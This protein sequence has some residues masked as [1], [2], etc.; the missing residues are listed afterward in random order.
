MILQ[1]VEYEGTRKPAHARIQDPGATIL[2]LRIPD[3]PDTALARARKAGARVLASAERYLLL[4]DDDGFVVELSG[5]GPAGTDIEVAV[6]D[7]D[8][9][10]AA[11]RALGFEPVRAALQDN[12]RSTVEI[13]GAVGGQIRR[14]RAA[15]PDAAAGATASITFLEFQQ[16]AREP[17]QTGVREPGATVLMVDV[18]DLSSLLPKLTSAGFGVVSS[19]DRTAIVRDPNNLFLQLYERSPR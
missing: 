13:A 8:K 1:L 19:G 4:Q 6:A 10:A 11:Y 15:I 3:N 7:V 2:K 12:D 16:I 18:R 14:I 17:L 5:D 9:T